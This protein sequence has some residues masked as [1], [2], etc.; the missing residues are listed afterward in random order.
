[1]IVRCGRSQR[2]GSREIMSSSV[3]NMFYGDH[4]R[5][6]GFGLAV[7]KTSKAPGAT[8]VF[9]EL[10]KDIKDGKVDKITVNSITGDVQASI[11]TA[12]NSI[13]PFRTPTTTSL[14]C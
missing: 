5:P 4:T 13:P 1:V 14:R 8:P 2:G 9:S 6:G 11:R 3:R 7:F 12:T 10:V